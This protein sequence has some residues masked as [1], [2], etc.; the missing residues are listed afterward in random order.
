[1]NLSLAERTYGREEESKE[2]TSKVGAVVDLFSSFL[3]GCWPFYLYKGTTHKKLPGL[4]LLERSIP[5]DWSG[6]QEFRPH[7]LL[8]AYSRLG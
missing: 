3:S 6:E 5:H 1:M 7:G 2:G 4:C 8:N